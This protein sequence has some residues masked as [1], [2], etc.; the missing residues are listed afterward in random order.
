M[1]EQLTDAP[2]KRYTLMSFALQ[3]YVKKFTEQFFFEK[4]LK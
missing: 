1:S 2:R 4:N 3:I